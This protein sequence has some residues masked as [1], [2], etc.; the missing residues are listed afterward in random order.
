M[1]GIGP[2]LKDAWRLIRPYFVT[3]EERWS[4]RGLLAAIL[5]M[6]LSIVGLTV[7]LSYWRAEFYNTLQDKDWQSFVRLL[8]Y[9]RQTD[10]LPMPGFVLLSTL[11]IALF[12]YAVYL[13]Q[14][15]QICWR[16]WL[17]RQYLHEWLADRA[18]Y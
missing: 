8:L 16:R 5:A 6:R 2:F 17:T 18:Y 14:Y 3:S 7:V 1:R 4:A 12:V 13:T 15:L 9:Y 10:S 11:W